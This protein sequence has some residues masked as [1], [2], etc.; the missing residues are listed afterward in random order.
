MRVHVCVRVCA[1]TPVSVRVQCVC[2]CVC[3]YVQCGVCPCEQ[4]AGDPVPHPFPRKPCVLSPGSYVSSWGTRGPETCVNPGVLT[5]GVF[6]LTPCGG[7]TGSGWVLGPKGEDKAT[8]SHL[9]AEAWPQEERDW[10]SARSRAGCRASS[11]PHLRHGFL[12]L[13]G[14][15]SVIFKDWGGGGVVLM[16]CLRSSVWGPHFGRS[17]ARRR[18]PPRPS[19]PPAPAPGLP[20]GTLGSMS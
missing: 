11:G 14:R 10:I 3:A 16:L 2:R 8:C 13:W 9:D 4:H 12:S 18:W 7:V 1:H 17:A 20:G 5:C 15:R 19:C 6:P